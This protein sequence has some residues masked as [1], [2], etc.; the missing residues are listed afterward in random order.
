MKLTLKLPLAFAA[1]LLLM[2][3]AALYGILALHQSLDTYATTVQ[4]THVHERNADQF[5][6]LFKTQVQEWKNTLLRGKD[7]KALDK[8]WSAFQ[9]TERETA[10][11]AGQLLAALP[12]GDAKALVEK[13]AAA[14]TAMGKGYRQGFEAF[15]GAGFDPSAGDAAVKGMD[16][17][18]ARLLDEAGTRIAKD[19]AEIAAGAA[20]AGDRATLVSVVLMVVVT[21]LGV[22]GG[23]LFSRTIARPLVRAVA[24]ARNVAAG[25]LGQS[26]D[27]T[28]QDETAQ[29]LAALNDMQA[30]LAQVV[31]TVRNNAEGVATASA[32]IAQGNSD[33]SSRTEQ[34]ASA[35]EQ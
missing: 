6:V 18:P 12:A 25:D 27:S 2:L 22:V 19:S 11:Q 15:R 32:Q 1:A 35:L 8:H 17:E 5:A 28:G 24:V 34:Q 30:A 20:A 23:V 31:G 26:I 4:A 13:F 10:A 21:V 33:L 9:Q 29:L 14:H 7:P 3:G 16:R